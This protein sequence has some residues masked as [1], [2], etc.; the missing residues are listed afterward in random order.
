[1]NL[2][3]FIARKLVKGTPRKGKRASR[4]V[5]GIAVGAIALGMA[6]MIL[7]IAIVTGFQQQVRD[8]VVGFGSHVVVTPYDQ[9]DSYEGAPL[10]S[11]DSLANVIRKVPGVRHVQPYALKAGM[12]TTGEENEKIVIKGLSAKYD[13]TFLHSILVDGKLITMSDTGLSKQIVVSK[14]TAARL[15]IKTGD[16][17]LLYFIVKSDIR[18]RKLTV[19]GITDSG[20]E[21][22]DK[23]FAYADIRHLQQ[24]NGWDS[25]QA[26]GL[27]VLIDSYAQLDDMG[28]EVASILP[29]EIQAKTIKELR[30]DIFVWLEMQDVNAIIIL[31]LMLFVAIINIISAML[32]LILERTPMI[33]ILKA[34]GSSNTMVRTVFINYSAYLLVWGLI[35]GNVLG[36]GLCYAQQYFNLI[37]LPKESY[38]VDTVP[39]LLDPINILGLN[40]LV[41]VSS[42]LVLWVTSLV[43]RRIS[44]VKAIRLK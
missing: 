31:A 41:I 18:K 28:R 10:S 35:W 12:F 2:S 23:L 30:P 8:K 40:L 14:Y 5:V 37:K 20:F 33:G 9:N 4:T 22:F 42:A 43:I 6:V 11:A 32:V 19:S 25:A 27:E 44:P 38:Y 29:P 24:L 26:T 36:I 17:V 39:I 34:M 16:P 15:K 7:A 13:T 3:I 1:M 21:E